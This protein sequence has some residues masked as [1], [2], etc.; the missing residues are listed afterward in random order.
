MNSQSEA[1]PPTAYL[2]AFSDIGA[3]VTSFSWHV[4]RGVPEHLD[5]ILDT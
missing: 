5:G 4:T 3:P 2:Q 1:L